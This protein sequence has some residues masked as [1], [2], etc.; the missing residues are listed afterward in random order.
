MRVN[1]FFFKNEVEKNLEPFYVGVKSR[2][3]NVCPQIYLKSKF[4]VTTTFEE[5][6]HY[7]EVNF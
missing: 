5:I 1:C 6:S 3:N 7:N 2:I 4:V